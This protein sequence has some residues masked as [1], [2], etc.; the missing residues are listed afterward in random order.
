MPQ[1][2]LPIYAKGLSVFPHNISTPY[3]TT[4]VLSLRYMLPCSPLCMSISHCSTPSPPAILILLSCGYKLPRKAAPAARRQPKLRPCSPNGHGLGKRRF[5]GVGAFMADATTMSVRCGVGDRPTWYS[6][7]IH[8]LIPKQGSPDGKAKLPM[9]TCGEPLIQ[10]Q[11][12]GE[13]LGER[14]ACPVFNRH[15]FLAIELM[16][17]PTQSFLLRH[18]KTGWHFVSCHQRH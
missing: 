10:W 6:A 7:P 9:S 14:A 13:I 8:E 2:A 1:R 4:L 11:L 18:A 15:H 17:T 12:A 16:M 5:C 3:Q